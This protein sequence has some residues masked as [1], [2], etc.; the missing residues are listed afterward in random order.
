MPGPRGPEGPQGE[1]VIPRVTVTPA[2]N[3]YFYEPDSDLD[4]T[5]SATIPADQFT[6]DTGASVTDF[7]G[8]GP[9]SFYNLYINGI[10]QPGNL[11]DVSLA[12]L[13]F[14]EQS[15][16]IYAGTPVVLETVQLTANVIV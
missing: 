2:I 7:S 15:S 14:L 12:N 10:L 3:R 13:F 8:L 11:Y 4:L 1:V 9:E 5:M 16:T 6:N